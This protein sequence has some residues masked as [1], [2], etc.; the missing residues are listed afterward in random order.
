MTFG[1]A[2]ECSTTELTLLLHSH[3]I[4]SSFLA[5]DSRTSTPGIDDYVIPFDFRKFTFSI[6]SK[7][8]RKKKCKTPNS[9]TLCCMCI[10]STANP[11]ALWVGGVCIYMIG[12]KAQESHTIFFSTVF[13]WRR[14]EGIV[15]GG[16]RLYHKG[17]C[18]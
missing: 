18:S 7:N 15:G 4:F 8:I 5:V 9:I 13:S 16:G 1:L 6:N 10:V 2:D 3:Y 17:H 11:K 14:R 12:I